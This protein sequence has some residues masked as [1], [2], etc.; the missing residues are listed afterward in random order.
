MKKLIL[1]LVIVLIF[2]LVFFKPKTAKEQA[3]DNVKKLPEVQQYLKDVPNG[4]VEVD[5]E[6]EGQINI[7]VYEIK[8][9]HTATFNWYRVDVES[10]KM[11][12]QF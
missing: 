2:G 3:V 1:L 9:D 7:H 4:K 12:P 11:E 5:S 8:D 6:E 10:G